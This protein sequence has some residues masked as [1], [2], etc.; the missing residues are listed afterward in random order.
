MRTSRS[1]FSAAAWRLRFRLVLTNGLG[2]HLGHLVARIEANGVVIILKSAVGLAF[3]QVG[4][5]AANVGKRILGIP[6]NRGRVSRDGLVELEIAHR[7]QA[8]QAIHV[9]NGIIALLFLVAE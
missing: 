4:V 9:H 3:G 1:W 7:S 5:A 8:L 2:P 6:V